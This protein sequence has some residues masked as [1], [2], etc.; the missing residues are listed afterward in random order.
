MNDTQ[1]LYEKVRS[2]I[3]FNIINGKYPMGKRLKAKDLA[4]EL[5]VSRTPIN[6]ALN[7]LYDEGLLNYNRNIG[8]SVRI[9]T[10]DDIEEIFKIR[11]ALDVLSFRE[12]SLN[13]R[14]NDFSYMRRLLNKADLASKNGEINEIRAAA[15]LF[16][17][18]IY[19]FADMPR[20]T[21]I[22][23][24]LND[25]LEVL[26]KLSFDGRSENSRRKLS[27]EEHS[28]ILDLMEA[29]D[30]NSLEEFIIKHLEGSKNYII[31][32]SYK[33]KDFVLNE[34]EEDIN[35]E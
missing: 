2:E 20:L 19:D 10:V 12:A 18:A 23:A 32:E 30:F 24:N 4:E 28:K 27:I 34:K 16:N 29:K 35:E 31:G 21:M 17:E 11:T 1:S 14:E 3:K 22:I 6:K 26:R 8:Y 9:I 5:Y 15:K 13:M 33:Y 7:S 25:Y